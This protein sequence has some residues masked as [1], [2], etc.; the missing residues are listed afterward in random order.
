MLIF[1]FA[2]TISLSGFSQAIVKFR[3]LLKDVV[4]IA[5]GALIAQIAPSAAGYAARDIFFI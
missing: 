1:F 4:V 5:N 2:I 3:H